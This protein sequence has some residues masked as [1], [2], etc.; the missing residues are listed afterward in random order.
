MAKKKKSAL[1][2]KGWAKAFPME[3]P[4]DK[5]SSILFNHMNGASQKSH[6]KY[7]F[8]GSTIVKAS[9]FIFA[10]CS[11]AYVKDI[12]AL[13]LNVMK[14]IYDR[15]ALDKYRSISLKKEDAVAKLIVISYQTYGFATVYNLICSSL[16]SI[17]VNVNLKNY[18]KMVKDYAKTVGYVPNYTQ[19]QI[20]KKGNLKEEVIYVCQ[21]KVGPQQVSIVTPKVDNT[22]NIVSKHFLEV[23]GVLD[24]DIT[25]TFSTE[26]I[27]KI[28]DILN[29]IGLSF[30][31]LG[32][33]NISFI[34]KEVE[35]KLVE[36]KDFEILTYIGET[37]FKMLYVEY[38][39]KVPD[40][41]KI[42]VF[43]M[44]NLFSRVSTSKKITIKKDTLLRIMALLWIG[45]YISENPAKERKAR[46]FA[47]RIIKEAISNGNNDVSES[48]ANE[49]EDKK[50]LNNNRMC[51]ENVGNHEGVKD[52]LKPILSKLTTRQDLQIKIQQLREKLNQIE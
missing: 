45:G 17:I 27:S 35:E 12:D 39:N 15:Y 21:L 50:D 10:Y 19:Y 44:L 5:V 8:W 22:E 40:D 34:Y 2:P 49:K 29:L 48:D 14:V 7:V 43:Q 33:S 6:K 1:T 42:Q 11:G 46:N 16:S 9:C 20:F 23:Y 38:F 41:S 37:I 36:Q 18:K 26:N 28:S 3:L 30:S 4:E 13:S 32:Y 52:N 51:F 25:K 24:S 47:N 31:D